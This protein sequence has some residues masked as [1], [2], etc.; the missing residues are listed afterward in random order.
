MSEFLM[1]V[2]EGWTELTTADA[3]LEQ[4]GEQQIIDLIARNE[5][6]AAIEALMQDGGFI[7][8]TEAIIDFRMFRD[9][10]ANRI[11]YKLG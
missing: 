10:T 4:Q 3:F 7:G 9:G 2:P 8:P 1:I 6:W 5:G 11:W